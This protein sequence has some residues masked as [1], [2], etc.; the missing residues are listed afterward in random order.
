MK[1]KIL[2]LEDELRIAEAIAYGLEKE[3]LTVKI[4]NT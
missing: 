2:L 1:G 3:G 4:L